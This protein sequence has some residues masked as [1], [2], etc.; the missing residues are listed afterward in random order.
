MPVAPERLFRVLPEKVD[1]WKL[2][3]SK[4]RLD[5]GMWME[6]DVVRVFEEDFQRTNGKQ[7]KPAT[8]IFAIKDTAKAK[9]GELDLFD[10]FTPGK[11]PGENYE[12]LY[13]G[14]IPAI[15]T[16]YKSKGIEVKFLI[17]RRFLLTISLRD[18]PSRDLQN[19]FQLINLA[20]LEAIPDGPIVS[21]PEEFEGIEIDELD[22]SKSSRYISNSALNES[23][24]EKF[25]PASS[26][27]NT[28]P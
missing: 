18:Q 27:E 12:Y 15:F 8:T 26:D 4:G 24:E 7:G 9:G 13:L 1:G 23:P 6:S 11:I 20:I 22:P 19:W 17:K 28:N 14:G 21:L 5:V 10:N 16:D 25:A 2:K 3:R